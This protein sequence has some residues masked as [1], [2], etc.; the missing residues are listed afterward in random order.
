MPEPIQSLF[1]PVFNSVLGTILI[2]LCLVIIWR[3][4]NVYIKFPK[5]GRETIWIV[6]I[7]T[8]LI[9]LALSYPAITFFGESFPIIKYVPYLFFIIVIL[10]L[11]K[12]VN[13]IK[14]KYPRG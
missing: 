3:C 10:A 7:A 13:I 1:E 2:I 6:V 14:E 11:Y 12:T 9:F 5:M 4:L 8:N